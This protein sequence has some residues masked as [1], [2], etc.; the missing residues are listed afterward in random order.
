MQREELTRYLKEY[1]KAD[2][3][4]DHCPNGLQV[5]GRVEVERVVCGVS[6]SVELFLRALELEAD[7]VIVHH[8]ILWKPHLPPVCG[9][10]RERLRLLLTHDVNLYG[11]HLP[12]D[13]HP[14]VG[15]NARLVELLDLDTPEPFGEYKGRPIGMRADAGG[16]GI[17]ELSA[18][19]E[20]A[21]EREPLVFPHGPEAIHGVGVISGGAQSELGQAV[22]SGLDAYVTGEV[23]ESTLHHA[24]EEG[25]HFISA[26]HYA[27]EKVG[28][29]ALG[30]H[31]VQQFGLT[32][33]FVDVPNPI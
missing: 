7:T 3:F 20:R 17:D 1:L 11:F 16:I 9:G 28:I 29:Q 26:G 10:L 4:E 21:L 8:G 5:E 19:I 13:A 18:R 15:N 27:T 32:V 30:E 25:I 12:L 22:S 14:E 6:A 31:L 33:E 24:K 23:S 2:E